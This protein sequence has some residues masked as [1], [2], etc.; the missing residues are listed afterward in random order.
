[1][2][3]AMAFLALALVIAPAMALVVAPAMAADNSKSKL[4]PKQL[5]W[6][7]LVWKNINGDW[8]QIDKTTGVIVSSD[9]GVVDVSQSTI[10]A[11]IMLSTGLI[12]F[13]PAANAAMS[14][15]AGGATTGTGMT[16]IGTATPAVAGL[17]DLANR[18]PGASNYVVDFSQDVPL[19]TQYANECFL[20]QRALLYLNQLYNNTTDPAAQA[21]IQQLWNQINTGFQFLINNPDLYK[22]PTGQT[23]DTTQTASTDPGNLIADAINASSVVDGGG[24]GDDVDD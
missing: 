24:A 18:L 23:P 5:N 20:A 14:L 8:Y 12:G 21:Q 2:R 16:V 7:N 1:M 9:L 10:A 22:G 3:T 13:T 15:L 17:V 11:P 19:A 6:K 4:K